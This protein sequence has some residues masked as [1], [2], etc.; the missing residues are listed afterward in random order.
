[1]SMYVSC[2]V[3]R[4]KTMTILKKVLLSIFSDLSKAF[5]SVDHNVLTAKLQNYGFHYI[6]LK[7]WLDYLK[8]RGQECDGHASSH[9]PNDNNGGNQGWNYTMTFR[10]AHFLV[11]ITT[12]H[13]HTYMEVC[14]SVVS[15]KVV[16]KKVP[17]L[18]DS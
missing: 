7:Q 1:M 14:D 5:D 10:R 3:K 16:A 18:I 15:Y 12:T 6:A 4:N 8:D 9:T 2:N 11:H 13:S 17:H